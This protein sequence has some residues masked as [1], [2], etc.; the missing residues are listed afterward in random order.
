MKYLNDKH[1]LGARSIPTSR[2]GVSISMDKPSYYSIVSGNVHRAAI[3]NVSP[4]YDRFY[5][6]G[7]EVPRFISKGDPVDSTARYEEGCEHYRD[8]VIRDMGYIG[9]IGFIGS[10]SEVQK[11]YCEF[12]ETGSCTATSVYVANVD[13]NTVGYVSYRWTVNG[14]L[15]TETGSRLSVDS[16]GRDDVDI[17]ISVKISDKYTSVVST[18]DSM[19]SRRDATQDNSILLYYFDMTRE[20]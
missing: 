19:H 8:F 7:I 18:Y 2:S 9:H 11:G 4:P 17:H 16:T 13:S 14:V 3:F 10:I 12:S 6:N 20:C 15:S 1:K 5:E